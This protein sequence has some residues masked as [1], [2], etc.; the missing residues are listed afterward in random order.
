MANDTTN[1]HTTVNLIVGFQ[2]VLL[3]VIIIVYLF[4]TSSIRQQ[5]RELQ[6]EIREKAKLE[7][8]TAYASQETREALREQLKQDE[9]TIRE[10]QA[11]IQRQSRGEQ[12]NVSNILPISKS[13]K[14]SAACEDTRSKGSD[15]LER[16]RYTVWV[17]G[18]ADLLGK[19]AEVTYLF[20]HPTFQ[21]KLLRSSNREDRFKVGYIGWG[22]LD[23]VIVTYILQDGSRSPVDFNMCSA[24]PPQCNL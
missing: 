13:L 18:P 22:C 6:S 11:A 4:V 15:N 23:S 19:I 2:I 20:D 1:R 9:L 14:P 7:S 3:A 17:E 16:Y 10:L 5:R 21:N 8:Q 24:L 12:Q